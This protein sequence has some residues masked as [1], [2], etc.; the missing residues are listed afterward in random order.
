MLMTTTAIPATI[1]TDAELIAASRG[2]SREAFGQ[3]VRKYQ[4]MVSGLIYAACGD[5][6]R[7]EDVAQE[8]F[9]SAWK[10][11]SGLTDP[12]KLPG[13]LCQIARRRIGDH[14]RESATPK[15]QLQRE[16]DSND[17]VAA[18][19]LDHA[20]LAEESEILWRTL[21]RLPQPY[22][23]TLVL[24]YRQG[25]STAEV[26][27]AM[28]T[29]DAGV[30]QRLSRGREMLREELAVLLERNLVAS[31]PGEE[32]SLAVVAA[33]PLAAST[34]A[35]LA[36]TANGS[37]A[38]KGGG[39]LF[40]LYTWLAPLLAMASLGLITI[41]TIRY[42]DAGRPRR[43][44]V[45]YWFSFW[46]VIVVWIV[47]C[48]KLI[49]FGDRRHWDYATFLP[50]L[51][52][53]GCV[54]GMSLFGLMAWGGTQSVAN[55]PDQYY[56]TFHRFWPRFLFLAPLIYCGVGWLVELAT[57][58]GDHQSAR[59]IAGTAILGSALCAWREAVQKLSRNPI[60]MAYESWVLMVAI[61]VLAIDCRLR[62]WIAAS[63]HLNV[64][65]LQQQMPLWSVNLFGAVL[66][67]WMSLLVW[68]KRPS[69]SDQSS[70]GF[71][72]S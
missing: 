30:R 39:A 64:A 28:E 17:F 69:K 41:Q 49:S 63:S 62:E 11:L 4:A 24:Y 52:A 21:S 8:T 44:L 43:Y 57:R 54:Y 10:S 9:I 20:A 14:F 31:A 59:L 61:I 2:G 48:N 37:T 71:A 1:R 26:A 15:V 55:P 3:I 38:A 72:P 50:A 45:G 58:A 67:L 29:T 56:S 47:A 40:V 68:G 34:T 22:R 7:S 18:E 33:L 66:V 23:E 36:A 6:H 70:V 46:L 13:W 65:N 12:A 35:G 60:K 16:I 27:A 5:L 25:R 42:A 53:A 32:F 51:A 19:P